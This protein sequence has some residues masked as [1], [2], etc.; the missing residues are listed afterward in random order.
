MNEGAKLL[1]AAAGEMSEVELAR[2]I[3]S[4]QSVVHRWLAGKRLPNV[5]NRVMLSVLYG[6]PILSWDN[7]VTEPESEPKAVA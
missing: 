6:I 4:G 3:N 5:Q 7:P 2:H 1:R